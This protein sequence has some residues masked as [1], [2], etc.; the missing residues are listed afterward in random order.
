MPK[1]IAVVLAGCGR[2]DGSEVHESTLSLLYLAQGGALYHCF[3]PN[4]PQV[5]VIDNL[6]GKV[7]EGATRNQMVEAARIARGKIQP[8]ADLEP[9]EFDGLVVPGGSGGF[10]NLSVGPGN[11]H[12]QLRRVVEGFYNAG[13]P[14]AFICIAPV[15]AARVLG[16][17][18]VELTIGNDAETAAEIERTGAH[19]IVARVNECVADETLKVVSTPAYMLGPGIAD[20]A[21]GIQ[22]CIKKLLSWA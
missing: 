14:M 12:P 7:S 13:K 3:A 10:K 16:V 20:I 2:M 17:Q 1:K 22:S 11:V 4:D 9:S 21:A 15:L 6:T 5:A 8:L 19:H 18:G